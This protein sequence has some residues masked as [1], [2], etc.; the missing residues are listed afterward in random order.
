MFEYRYQI[1]QLC[2]A[3]AAVLA[4]TGVLVLMFGPI[5]V[6][7]F[8]LLLEHAAAAVGLRHS[9]RTPRGTPR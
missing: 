9:T 5:A 2:M 7:V 8:C 6:G 4:V 1:A 3:A